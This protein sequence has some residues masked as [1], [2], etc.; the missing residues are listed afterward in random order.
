MRTK[1][2]LHDE[3]DR[4]AYWAAQPVWKRIKALEI[5]R[6]TTN[7]SVYVKQPFPKVF[8]ILRKR[9]NGYEVVRSG[10]ADGSES[11]PYPI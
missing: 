6:G 2:K 8:R 7:D 11:R 9:K 1:R 3:P 4:A 5:I 10:S